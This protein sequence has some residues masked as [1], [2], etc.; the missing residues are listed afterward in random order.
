MMLADLGA[1]V[2]KIEQPEGGDPMRGLPGASPAF[3]N[4]NRNKESVT[5]DLR[6]GREVLLRLAAQAD[7]L[8]EGFR[9]GVADRLGIGYRRVARVNPRIVYCSIS[10]YGQSGPL[11]DAPGHDVNYLARSGLLDAT[12]PPAGEPTIPALLSADLAG[13]ALMSLVGILS[14]LLARERTRRGQYL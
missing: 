4:L 5:L 12:G 9:P 13:G 6:R 11:R 3:E 2:I 1:R 7:V 10:G 8:V 14:A